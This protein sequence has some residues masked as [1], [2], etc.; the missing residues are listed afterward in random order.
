MVILH[1]LL[2]PP[3][4]PKYELHRKNVS[5][6]LRWLQAQPAGIVGV[7]APAGFG[8]TSYLRQLQLEAHAAGQA[9]VWLSLRNI[10]FD[11]E[12]LLVHLAE[13][14]RGA[15]I[16]T[17]APGGGASFASQ[18]I[19]QIQSAIELSD[20][21]VILFL[22]DVD[23]LAPGPARLI[24]G[25]LS[26]ELASLRIA[27]TARRTPGMRLGRIFASGRFQ[28]VANADL[29]LSFADMHELL[30]KRLAHV[31]DV[32][33]VGAQFRTTQGWPALV[34]LLT[35][36][37]GARTPTTADAF[38][39]RTRSDL[40]SYLKEEVLSNCSAEERQLLDLFALVGG[41]DVQ[42]INSIFSPSE[43]PKRIDDL[44]MAN[45]V[46]EHSHD[47]LGIAINPVLADYL[48]SELKITDIAR[49]RR[50]SSQIADWH[51]RNGA[52]DRAI[53]HF[54][55]A[56]N[57]ARVIALL[58]KEGRRVTLDGL[59][60]QC[61]SWIERLSPQTAHPNPG[62]LMAE[63]WARIALYDLDQGA[64][65]VNKVRG[66]SDDG[67][68]FG[69]DLELCIADA[70]RYAMTDDFEAAFKVIQSGFRVRLDADTPFIHAAYSNF[71]AWRSIENG[72]FDEG[73]SELY[74][75]ACFGPDAQ[76]HLAWVYGTLGIA[77]SFSLEANMVAADAE[78]QRI[79]AVAESHCGYSSTVTASAL[80]PWLEVL[81]EMNRIDE[82]QTHLVGRLDLVF[83]AC[84]PAGLSRGVSAMAKALYLHGAVAE[85]IA[86]LQ[87]LEEVGAKRLLN[88]LRATSL[89]TQIWIAQRQG[90]GDRS[91]L[92]LGRLLAMTDESGALG[93]SAQGEINF[94]GT[95]SRLRIKAVTKPIDVIEEL[96]RLLA[97]LR[98][99]PWRRNQLLLL[100]LLSS[101]AAGSGDTDLAIKTLA[102]CLETAA[103]LQ[104]KR[105]IADE[106]KDM[107]LLQSPRL[108]AVLSTA[109]NQLRTELIYMLSGPDSMSDDGVAEI[110]TVR[111]QTSADVS[112][113]SLITFTGREHEVLFLVE[114]GLPVK[115]IAR[116]L[117]VSPDTAKFHLKNVYQK[118][119]VHD[120]VAASVAIRE[121]RIFDVGS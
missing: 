39:A 24:E 1:S 29:L 102:E 93:G 69:I 78:Y 104:I 113:L 41:I 115:H 71:F 75:A 68:N 40:A 111:S 76:G 27:F 20:K 23:A 8:K 55:D 120:R 82:M 28:R 95:L 119:G 96:E 99:A 37:H 19:L 59:P 48:R 31:P 89:E 103:P 18:G 64:A 45:P 72:R 79:I 25:L 7:I 26:P 84:L 33:L 56:G 97:A 4:A 52:I 118:L 44:V 61:I 81:Y 43:C 54:I 85:A 10:A 42:S 80:G 5:R 13:A 88:R 67:G 12:L 114:K 74:R 87:R 100:A 6:T 117:N 16:S 30:R 47:G 3:P 94:L 92:L 63:A 108:E 17:D 49:F 112:K 2:A 105:A 60:D 86:L 66:L 70:F 83:R 46:F 90:K 73:R 35:Q 110:T 77:E 11:E 91:Q 9:V 65:L 36:S 121:M 21:R 15:G 53:E 109:A 22:D 116:A 34:Q 57:E 32:F 14:L 106:M 38:V 101:V 58:S 62:L 50:L 98:D 107:R 51:E